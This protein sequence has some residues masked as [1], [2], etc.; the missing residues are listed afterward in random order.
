MSETHTCAWGSVGGQ[1]MKWTFTHL[2]LPHGD[3]T[4]VCREEDELQFLQRFAVCIEVRVT[5]IADFIPCPFRM[6]GRLA[7]V[8]WLVIEDDAGAELAVR[9]ERK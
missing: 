7:R 3:I 2:S 4:Y 9:S 1:S 5:V 6:V 8:T